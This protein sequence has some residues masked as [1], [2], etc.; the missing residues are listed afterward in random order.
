MPDK[1]SFVLGRY[2]FDSFGGQKREPPEAVLAPL[3]Q[4]AHY[5]LRL[6]H[7]LRLSCLAACEFAL[8]HLPLANWTIVPSLW[9]VAVRESPALERVLDARYSNFC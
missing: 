7:I 6:P 1:R 2:I 8:R 9:L 4:T 3:R 5:P